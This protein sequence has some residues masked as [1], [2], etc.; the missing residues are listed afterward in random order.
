MWLVRSPL[1]PNFSETLNKDEYICIVDW[2][3][4]VVKNISS[5]A[6]KI[7][8][9]F[10]NADVTKW[11]LCWDTWNPSMVFQTIVDCSSSHTWQTAY[12]YV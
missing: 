12:Q 4:F 1:E 3:I 6:Y 5:V 7:R 9:K 8:R 11:E 10:F 2:E